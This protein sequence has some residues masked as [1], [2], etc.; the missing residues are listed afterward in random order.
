VAPS[1]GSRCHCA[2]KPAFSEPNDKRTSQVLGTVRRES[3]L[4]ATTCNLERM[5]QQV[6]QARKSIGGA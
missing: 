5:D 2:S 3:I 1:S 4:H 6:L